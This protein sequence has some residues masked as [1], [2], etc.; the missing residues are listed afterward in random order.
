MACLP[1][2]ISTIATGNDECFS[3]RSFYW[4]FRKFPMW[5]RGFQESQFILNYILFGFHIFVG[6]KIHSFFSGRTLWIL[7]FHDAPSIREIEPYDSILYFSILKHQIIYPQ[8]WL[9][10]STESWIMIIYSYKLDVCSMSRYR[11]DSKLVYWS[12]NETLHCHTLGCWLIY[13]FINFKI[14]I[15]LLAAKTSY[16]K[17]THIIIIRKIKIVHLYAFPNPQNVL[18][19]EEPKSIWK[20]CLDAFS[21][22]ILMMKSCD[23]EIDSDVCY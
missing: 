2:E 11:N 20:H 4:R 18:F 5:T 23:H 9:L 1:T 21:N 12:T 16:D 14:K 8:K 15:I 7:L 22:L 10:E 19:T 13:N 6:D 3:A 17:S